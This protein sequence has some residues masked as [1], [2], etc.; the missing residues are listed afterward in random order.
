MTHP[1]HPP[2]HRLPAAVLGRC[3]QH[4][5]SARIAGL[6]YLLL[7]TYVTAMLA[8]AGWAVALLKGRSGI[9][10]YEQILLTRLHTIEGQG[11]EQLAAKQYAKVCTTTTTTTTTYLCTTNVGTVVARW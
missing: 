3:T 11:H 9:L 4:S 7:P 2:T 8:V 6:H 1:P 5:S 10:W